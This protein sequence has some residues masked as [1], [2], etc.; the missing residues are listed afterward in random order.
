MQKDNELTVLNQELV[1]YEGRYNELIK[2]GLELKISNEETKKQAIA[3]IR[4]YNLLI[5][6]YNSRLDFWLKPI[7]IHIKNI[8]KMVKPYI[9][10]LTEI[11]GKDSYSGLRGQLSDYETKMEDVRRKEEERLRI[12]QQKKYDK[13][14][15]KAEKKGEIAPPPPPPVIVDVKKEEGVSYSNKWTFDEMNV[16]LDKVPEVLNG[17]RLKILNE[18]AVQK[19]IEAGCRE[20]P[21]IKIYCK[22]VPIIRDESLENL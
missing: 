11:F 13:E 12:E 7:K 16:D 14:V 18:K 20:I 6:S 15:A 5:D 19:I 22:K 17:I 4:E 9:K 8:E 1:K 2:Q 21:G 3:L 10:V